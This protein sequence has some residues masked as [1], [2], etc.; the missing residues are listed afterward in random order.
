MSNSRLSDYP[1][2]NVTKYGVDGVISLNCLVDSWV[3]WSLILNF[4]FILLFLINFISPLINV[5]FLRWLIIF[6]LILLLQSV[7]HLM[8][9]EMLVWRMMV[10]LVFVKA[11]RVLVGTHLQ[12]TCSLARCTEPLHHLIHQDQLALLESH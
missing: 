2:V 10:D 1:L 6:I 3:Q 9:V 7:T 11:L 4:L 8:L 12:W 5:L